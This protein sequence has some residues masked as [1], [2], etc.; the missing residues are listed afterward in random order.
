ML[1]LRETVVVVAA[2]TTEFED[3]SKDTTEPYIWL[4][5]QTPR[6]CQLLTD[7]TRVAKQCAGYTVRTWYVRA[8]K[9]NK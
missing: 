6:I 2:P 3:D 8:V 9:K 7:S 5:T 1:L 4:C